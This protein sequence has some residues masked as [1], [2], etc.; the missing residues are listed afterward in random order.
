MNIGDRYTAPWGRYAVHR[1][2]VNCEEIVLRDL[3]RLSACIIVTPAEL[4]ANYQAQPPACG[5]V[6]MHALGICTCASKGGTA[7]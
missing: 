7:A 2:D 6:T 5:V 4:A 1:I 3:D